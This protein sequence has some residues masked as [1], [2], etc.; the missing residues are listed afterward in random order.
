MRVTV[1]A[2]ARLHLGFLNLNRDLGWNY[3]GIGVGV[4]APR[5]TLRATPGE[6]LAVTGGHEERILGYAQR[7][8]SHFGRTWNARLEVLEAIP[9][10]SGLGSGT[11][12]ALAVGAALLKLHG[13]DS[14]PR[15]LAVIL[16]RGGRSGI[17][18]SS[19]ESG[20]FILE[21]GHKPASPGEP[22][23]PSQVVLRRE[24]PANWRFVLVLADAPE[25]LSG[26]EEKKAFASLGETR[27]ITETICRIA[28]LRL[29]PALIEED[30]RAFGNA[31][32]EID[33]QT[34]LFFQQAQG[35]AY[36]E[37]AREMIAQLMGAG[38]YGVG[39]SSWGPCL[40][41]LV[42]DANEEAVA[43]AAEKHLED[44]GRTGR[45]FV[46]RARNEGA[47]ILVEN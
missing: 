38:A 25:G 42:D 2:Y 43:R 3:G 4:D 9:G 14:P 44:M 7:L 20:G 32:S 39:Q 41:V 22:V 36:R 21:A 18:V 6:G 28:L 27:T 5:I 35:G 23:R 16:G 10:H 8:S 13:M 33:M 46:T 40:Y 45:V 17:G 19:F 34:G 31:M 15:E 1:R 29:L 11:Q 26:A 47:E 37:D 24:F 12:W 30:I